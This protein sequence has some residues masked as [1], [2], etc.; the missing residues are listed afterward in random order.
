MPLF[1]F[2]CQDCGNKFEKMISNAEKVKLK[3]PECNSSNIQQL[4]SLF[5]SKKSR[6]LSDNCSSC[7]ARSSGM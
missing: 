1:D 5:N 4:L 2:S 3:C 6:E 7:H